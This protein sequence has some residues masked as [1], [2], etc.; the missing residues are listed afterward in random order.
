MK[1]TSQWGI[2]RPHEKLAVG[3]IFQPWRLL[4]DRP[5]RPPTVKFLTVGAS[6]DRL[7]RSQ[8]GTESRALCRSTDPV[9]RGFQR[10]EGL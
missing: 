8:P 6:V 7:G 4:V 9:D 5:G 3:A 2:N 1:N 10:A